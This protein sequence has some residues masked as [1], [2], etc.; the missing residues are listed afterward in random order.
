MSHNLLKTIVVVEGKDSFDLDTKESDV[1][2]KEYV[3]DVLSNFN[4]GQEILVG[5]YEL[6]RTYKLSANPSA[7][8]VTT[9][10][11]GK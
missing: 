11:K 3:E 6:V 1:K 9:P 7:V 2:Q 10:K 4:E 5:V 8:L